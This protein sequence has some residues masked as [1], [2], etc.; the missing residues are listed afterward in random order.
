LNKIVTILL[1]VLNVFKN[2]R[3]NFILHIDRCFCYVFVI[4]H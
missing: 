4:K 1:Y 3:Y 2:W